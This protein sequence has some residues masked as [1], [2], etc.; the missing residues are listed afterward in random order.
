MKTATVR[1]Y[2]RLHVGLVDLAGA[3]HRRFGGAGFMIAAC[4]T[5]VEAR[6]E[7]RETLCGFDNREHRAMLDVQEALARLRREFDIP[8]MRLTIREAPPEHIGLG[9]KTTL[10]LCALVAALSAAE[11]PLHRT[12]IQKASGRGGASGVGVHAF[13]DGGFIVDAG[14]KG[15]RGAPLLPSGATA[16]QSVPLLAVRHTVPEDWRFVLAIPEGCGQF[17]STREVQ[18]FRDNT[19]VPKEECLQ[20]LATLYHGVLPAVQQADLSLLRESLG[21]LHR[22]GFKARELAAQPDVVKRVLGVLSPV[23]RVAAGLSSLGPVVYAVC[24][25]EDVGHVSSILGTVSDV[26]VLV[27]GPRNSGFEVHVQ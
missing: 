11:L 26:A 8:P 22:C 15:A 23:S 17:S 24:S 7:P 16:P 2:P 14:H 9:S 5:V 21:E 18:F 1:C 20:N 4:E 27:V 10:V 6:P 13:F 12:T 3:T 25:Q 19:P